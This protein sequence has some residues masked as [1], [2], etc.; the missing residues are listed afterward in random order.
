MT[1]PSPKRNMVP[2]AVLMRSG[3]VSLTTARPVNTAQPKTTVNST[4]PM[5]NVFNKAHSTVRRPIN[6]KTSTKNS[7][8]NQ[9]VNTARPKAVL[10][11]VKGNHVN[12][13]RPKAVLNA[14]KG[15]QVNAV[16][17]LACW[18]WKPKTKVIDHG[19]PQQDLQEKGVID[20]GCLRHMTGN[21]SYLTDFEE[22]DGG[23]VAFGGNPKGGKITGRGT[24]KTGNLDFENVYFVRELKFNIFSV[25]QMCDKKNSVLFNDTEC[26]VLS[27]N[28]MLTDESHVLLKV[29]R[30]NNMYSVD[31]KNIVPKGGLICLF[32]KATSDESKLWHRRLGQINFKTMNK[33]V[34]GNLVRGLP[35]KLFKNN[36]TC[37]A[38][39]KGKQHRASCKSETVSSISQPLHMLH[40]DLFGPTFVKSLM[41]K[42]YCL[43]VTDDYSRFSWVFFLATKDETSG[44]FKSF[45]TRVE[46]LVD[47]RVKVIRCDN[48]TEFKNKE[49]NRFCERKADSKLPTTFGAEAVNTACYVQNGVLVTKPHNKTPYELFLGRKPALDFMRPFG[50]PVTILNTIDHLGKF[51]G[52]ADEGFFVGYSI[53]SKAFR[54]GPNWLFDIDALTKSMNYKPVVTGNQS[55]GNSGTKA[56]DD[57]GKARME[58]VLGKD[59]I[60]LPLWTADPPF[61]QTS[62]S[63]PDAGF[64]PSGNDEK[65]KEDDVNSTNNVNADGTNEVN[66]V[67]AGMNNL[68]TTIQVSSIPTT[69]IHKDHPLEQVIGDL[70]S[71]TLTRQ[72]SKNLEE[73]R[74]TQKVDLPNGKRAIGTKWVFKNK[75]DERGTVIRNKA[76]LVA[77]GYTQKE[78]IDYNEV[79]APVARIEAIRL[80]LAYAS[81]KDFVVY[82]MD[83]KSAFLYGKIEKE[84]YVCQPPGFEDPNFP[85]RVYK[86]EEALYGLHQAPRA[87]YETL[88]TYLL[89]NRFQRGKIDKTLFIRRDK[90]D[91]LLVQV[92]V[93]DII[94]GST[95]KSLCTE[96][97][98]M[99]HKKFQMSS[100]GELTFFLGL[101][102]KHKKDEI[103]IS[104]DKYVTEILKKFGF[105]DVKTASTPMETHKPLLKDEDGEEVD[106]HLYRSM[107]GSLMYLTSSRPDILF[108]VCAC[109]RYQVN[110][111]VSHQH[112]V[113]RIFRYLK[114][115][116]KLGLWYPKDSTFD[117]VAYTDSDYARAS[118][119]R[120]STIGGCQFLRCRLI[121][122]QCKKQ[123]VVA[124]STTEA[125]YVAALNEAV[126]K[127]RDD[128]LVRAATTASSLEAECQETMGD[129]IAQ[130]RFENVSKISNDSLLTGVNT[131]RSD[132]DRLKLNELMEF[133]KKL[134][135]RNKSRTHGLKRLYRIGSSRRVESSEDEGLG[136]ED[137]SKQGR[138]A[139]IDA[140]EGITLVDESAENKGRFNDEDMF[141]VND[142]DD[143]E[144][145]VDNV[146][147]VKTAEETVNAVATT[148]PV[149]TT[150]TIP[151]SAA[152]IT[153]VEITLA[154]ALAEL[155]TA[156]SKVKGIIFKEPVESTTT[157]PIPLPK[158]PQ[159]KGKAKGVVMQEPEPEKPLI[160]KDQIRFD[161]EIALKLQ[162]G[163]QAE[164]EEEER[165]T[166]EK[167][168]QIEE[169][170]IVS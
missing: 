89:D 118:L 152:T 132:E 68:D 163:L 31:L 4:R 2:K 70:Q 155:K 27:P 99:M 52:K 102:V 143:D 44:I 112:A 77:Q 74:R 107:I 60:L 49:M 53:N 164:L 76:R 160:K 75:L 115:Q 35:S 170:N 91:I 32:A 62:K 95:K 48:G 154:Q 125:E 93:D 67:E 33:L 153:Y 101:Q 139:D 141:G 157:T 38:C 17:A 42:M 56:C 133:F 84:V 80:F 131:P 14:L 37:V 146:D 147:V 114:G 11:V 39:Q 71:S 78:G 103:F 16:K 124:N 96:F 162:A 21:M 28:F 19:N 30:K 97:E 55:N 9:K 165:L 149:S 15:N 25:S 79:F 90:G 66:A 1:H 85:D 109:A 29:P 156:K 135:R 145:I 63:S 13:A 168:Q 58:I 142:L 87:W 120:K 119:D 54:I 169:A 161:E 117:L 134:E 88:S 144:V 137:A 116:P 64:K 50:C 100:I 12:T 129:T 86:V 57:A 106:V 138:I 34:K 22:I 82:P 136:K 3:L 5:T 26:I 46:N 73:Y 121:S 94:F 150:N 110:P 111:K 148:I 65:K 18:V 59:Y 81:F 166:R 130:T 7:N 151:V 167:A 105:T 126:Y 98:K 158:P 123:T 8:F 83:V 45:I 127:E 61:S 10:N 36:Q 6:N 122:W 69:R 72:M 24:I 159:D 92:Y 47:Q 128:S 20:S 140:D 108:A 104:Q 113:K 40:I 41:K 43:V 23:Y 51:D